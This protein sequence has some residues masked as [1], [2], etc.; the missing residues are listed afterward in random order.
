MRSRNF[1]KKVGRTLPV[2]IFTNFK[3]AYKPL[4]ITYDFDFTL[5][6]G[7]LFSY[8]FMVGS[9]TEL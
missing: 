8:M 1:K 7:Y 6:Y 5:L 2:E 4:L 3:L 9:L